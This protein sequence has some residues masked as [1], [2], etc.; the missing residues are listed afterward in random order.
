MSD[1]PV[2]ALDDVS[3]ETAIPGTFGAAIPKQFIPKPENYADHEETRKLIDEMIYPLLQWVRDERADL[4]EEWNANRR[5]EMMERDSGQKY[6]G[7]S[8]AYLPLY[9][10]ALKT[11]TSALSTGLFPSDDYM[12]VADRSGLRTEDAKAVK[13]YMQWEFETNG[14]VRRFMKPFLRQV[15][16]NGNAVLKY[17]YAK[18]RQY[19]GR[20]TA[21]GSNLYA[22]QFRPIP[23]KEGLHV[24]VR[25]MQNFY[26]FPHTAESLEEC[27]VLFEDIEMSQKQIMDRIKAGD[28][29]NGEEALHAPR[30]A[31]FDIDQIDALYARAGITSTSQGF[32][33]YLE[34][35]VLTEVWCY[36]KLPKSAYVDGEDTDCDLPCRILMAGSTPVVVT[37]NPYWHQRPPYLVAR[38]NVEPGVFYGYGAAKPIRFLQ[39]LANDYAN[40]TNDCGIYSLNPMALVNPTF[41]QGPMPKIRPGVTIPVLSVT[42]AIR[43]EKPP[44]ELAQYGAQMMNMWAGMVSDF[45]GAPP[46]LQGNVSKGA[47]TAT[48][49]QILQRNSL[50]PLQDIVEDIELDV[51]VQLLYGAWVNAQQFRDEAVMAMVAGRPIK[52]SPE[53]LDIDAEF[54][55]LGSSQAVNNQVRSQ[56]AMTLVQAVAPIVP[57]LNQQGY[58]VDFKPLIEKVYS[59]GMG[60]RGFDAFIHKMNPQE[61]MAMMGGMGAINPAQNPNAPQAEQAAGIRSALEQVG[62]EGSAEAVPGEAE[63]FAAV[64]Q[65]VEDGNDGTY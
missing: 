36:L 8:D 63:D 57:L 61:Q 26:V 15:A 65:Q 28:F 64:R 51:M 56:Q 4:N 53:Q 27:S 9:N 3:I 33:P 47:K 2:L 58:V 40:Q 21:S 46:Q 17:R 30:P 12:D 31:Q 39:Y 29:K 55:W 34:R 1:G 13:A 50:A 5:M 10:N 43:F 48:G 16:G 32:S 41:I 59:D 62:G 23:R 44:P 6:N 20:R 38:Q 7:R 25:N 52:V 54:R 11:L 35:K 18:N 45:S 22:P 19:Q 14:Q 37:R 24:S 60:F 42:E 49:A